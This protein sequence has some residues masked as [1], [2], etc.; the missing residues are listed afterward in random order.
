MK[1]SSIAAV[2]NT[3][4]V[5]KDYIPISATGQSS[6][7]NNVVFNQPIKE[8]ASLD[9]LYPTAKSDTFLHDRRIISSTTFPGD[10]YTPIITR[11][12]RKA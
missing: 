3:Q 12:E 6:I 5:S 10:E 11:D 7:S 2:C 8:D 4:Y 9:H 1:S